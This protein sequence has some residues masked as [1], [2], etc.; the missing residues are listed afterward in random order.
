[1][2]MSWMSRRRQS[3]PFSRYSLSPERNSRRVIWISPALKVRLNLRRRI[4][5][6]TFGVRACGSVRRQSHLLADGIASARLFVALPGTD[7]FGVALGVLGASGAQ[8]GLVP[9][10]VGHVVL[11]FDLGLRD[12][13]V[14]LGVDKGERDLGHAG[15][16][17]LARAGEDD[18]LHV[19][20]AEE[21]RRLLAQHPGDGV[22]DVRL[23][24]AVGTDDGGDAVAL[25][26]EV[27]A[28]TERLEAEDLKLLQF[29]QFVLLKRQGFAN[30]SDRGLDAACS[31]Q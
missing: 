6:T 22:G 12:V 1:M 11:D 7:F 28:V 29:Q 16:L 2:K 23:A 24:T 10:G 26:A 14:D 19:H 21:A 25:E 27:G 18:V 9:I 20:A 5:R 13:A 4:L 3:L 8:S 30:M 17:A 31:D 15:G